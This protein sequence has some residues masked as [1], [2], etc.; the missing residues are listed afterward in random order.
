M[1][2]LDPSWVSSECAEIPFISSRLLKDFS[3]YVKASIKSFHFWQIKRGKNPFFWTQFVLERFQKH[4]FFSFQ[5]SK[6]EF[7]IGKKSYAE[8][9]STSERV[10]VN[11]KFRLSLHHEQVCLTFVHFMPCS[12]SNFPRWWR[13]KNE[14]ETFTRIVS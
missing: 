7:I 8:H 12:F 1:D 11:I 4:K 14:L 9:S 3:I 10:H 13:D 6:H 2:L 5:I